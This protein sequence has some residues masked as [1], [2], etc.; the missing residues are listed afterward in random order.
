MNSRDLKLPL[1]TWLGLILIRFVGVI[2]SMR[3]HVLILQI[4]LQ[5]RDGN[6]ALQQANLDA[7]GKIGL[8]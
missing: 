2:N 8:L 6:I 1:R 3:H 5:F 4:A 7:I